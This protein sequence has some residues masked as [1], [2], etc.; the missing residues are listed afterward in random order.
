MA[1][2]KQIEQLWKIINSINKEIGI[3]ESKAMAII[4]TSSIITAF[5]F[6]KSGILDHLSSSVLYTVLF[7]SCSILLLTAIIFA[8]FTIKPNFKYKSESSILHFKSILSKHCDEN[9]YYDDFKQIFR[10]EYFFE[11]QLAEQI[12][13][14]SKIA[15]RKFCFVSLS[16]YSFVSFLFLLLLLVIIS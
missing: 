4:S 2:E 15:K 8:L 7:I 10:N 11:K 9:S 16:I 5:L 13:V 6:S 12:I 14:K 3:A 1:E